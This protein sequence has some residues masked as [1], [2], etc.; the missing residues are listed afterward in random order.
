[1][2]LTYRNN[3]IIP[4]P[5]EFGEWHPGW[6]RENGKP[7]FTVQE[8]GGQN[9][10][11]LHA[12]SLPTCKKTDYLCLSIIYLYWNQLNGIVDSKISY[13]YQLAAKKYVNTKW[14]IFSIVSEITYLIES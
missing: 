12:T 14:E 3:L 10:I 6:G 9:H 5:G 11:L 7:F 4:V 2:S 13:V 8:G 1:M